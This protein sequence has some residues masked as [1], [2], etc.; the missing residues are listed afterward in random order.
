MVDN[1]VIFI[2]GVIYPF[3]ERYQKIYK[4]NRGAKFGEYTKVILYFSLKK[5]YVMSEEILDFVKFLENRILVAQ[6]M[7]NDYFNPFRTSVRIF[8]Q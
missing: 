6:S 1:S 3:G 2:Y 5:F 7:R 4:I 8:K